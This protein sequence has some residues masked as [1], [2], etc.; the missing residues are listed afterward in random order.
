M[1]KRILY[2]C[3]VLLALAVS[4]AANDFPPPMCNPD[5]DVCPKPR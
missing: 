2:S 3:A 4:I 5:V 1:V